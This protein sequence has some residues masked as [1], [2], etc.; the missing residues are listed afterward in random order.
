MNA[1]V[2]IYYCACPPES[3]LGWDSALRQQH[4]TRPEGTPTTKDASSSSSNQLLSCRKYFLYFS[5]I[6]RNLTGGWQEP[7]S[8]SE[9]SWLQREQSCRIS[10]QGSKICYQ[11]KP[12]VGRSPM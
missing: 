6:F 10:D 4:S 8:R 9:P 12:L 2:L 11:G 5:E 7:Q 1:P 3:H